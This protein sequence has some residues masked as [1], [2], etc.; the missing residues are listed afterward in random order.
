MG[1]NMEYH[2][3][4]PSQIGLDADL[5]CPVGIRLLKVGDDPHADVICMEYWRSSHVDPVSFPFFD[6]SWWFTSGWFRLKLPSYQWMEKLTK[7]CLSSKHELLKI[8]CL[9]VY[10][11]GIC[12]V[13]WNMNGLFFSYI[14]NNNPNWRAFLQR[15][16][17]HQPGIILAG[18][19]GILN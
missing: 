14:G 17:N 16:W 6:K 4:C 8:P 10:E 3:F 9:I 1:F 18:F 19:L 15:G 5:T 12:L 2:G 7:N 11:I 13:V